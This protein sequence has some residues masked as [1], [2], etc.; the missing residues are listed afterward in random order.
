ML[1][2]ISD[3]H[4]SDRT[5]GVHFLSPK[6]FDL[7]FR[8]LA[9]LAAHARSDSIRL[10]FLGDVFENPSQYRLPPEQRQYTGEIK[11]V[12]DDMLA[13]EKRHGVPVKIALPVGCTQRRLDC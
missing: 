8:R 11:A 2:F 1:A 3:L 12:L 6:A 5:A 9:D 13:T 10:V 7:A 4:I